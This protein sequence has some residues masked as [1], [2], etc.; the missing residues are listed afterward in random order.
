MKDYDPI[1]S[2][3]VWASTRKELEDAARE[4]NMK[5]GTF[6]S[7]VLNEWAVSRRAALEI[8]ALKADLTDNPSPE[9]LERARALIAAGC[10]DI[11]DWVSILANGNDNLWLD[12]IKMAI[13]DIEADEKE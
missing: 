9:L 8:E 13:F 1:V 3:R 11:P 12:V 10:Y 6:L 2:T 5:F 7:T 4:A